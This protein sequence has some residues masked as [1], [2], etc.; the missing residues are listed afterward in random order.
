M[1]T[2]GNRLV[3]LAG[4]SGA[5]G[6][7]LASLAAGPAAGTRMVNR[8]TLGPSTAAVHLMHDTGPVEPPPAGL[9]RGFVGFMHA[10]PGSLMS[11]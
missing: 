3:F 4:L 2:A 5:A 11:H 8:S 9:L 1:T 6:D 10:N 7:L